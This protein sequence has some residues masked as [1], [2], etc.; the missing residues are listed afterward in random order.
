[1]KNLILLLLLLP[2]TMMSQ[3]NIAINLAQDLR[4][5]TT[6]DSNS[7]DAFTANIMLRADL[8]SDQLSTGYVV[9]GVQYEYAD[10]DG[11]SFNR[12]S[13]NGGYTFNRFKILGNDKFEFTLLASYGGTVRTIFRQ[14]RYI[15]PVFASF[16]GSMS[17]SY[18][19]GDTRFRVIA[20]GQLLHRVDKT[21]M[22]GDDA[23][24]TLPLL[25]ADASGF[26]GIQ[27]TI[28]LDPIR[29]F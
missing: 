13:L 19:I 6:G 15:R 11:S 1:M 3:E 5:A 26:V 23:S 27:Y 20:V 10:L 2:L 14:D 8:Q 18:P 9:V 12:Y 16:S 21:S 17:L 4:M 22:Y 24:Y 25:N 29:R 7:N 28:K